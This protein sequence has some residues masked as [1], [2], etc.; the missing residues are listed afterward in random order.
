MS[1]QVMQFQSNIYE[2]LGI[3]KPHSTL[4]SFEDMAHKIEPPFIDS[5]HPKSVDYLL[6]NTP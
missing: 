1:S 3:R 4:K 6:A 5:S 2:A